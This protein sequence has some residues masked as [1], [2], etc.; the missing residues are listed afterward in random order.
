M[1]HPV[2]TYTD[3]EWAGLPE[4]QKADAWGA[5]AEALKRALD[6]FDAQGPAAKERW[7]SLASS[8]KEAVR[9][10]EEHLQTSWRLRSGGVE[11]QE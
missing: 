6:R 10:R 7:D 11:G 8:L 1:G 3:S 5:V 4:Q 9:A 2:W